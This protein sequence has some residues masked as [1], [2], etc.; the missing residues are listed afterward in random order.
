MSSKFA[1]PARTQ[2]TPAVCRKPPIPGPFDPAWPPKAATGLCHWKGPNPFGPDY[3]VQGLA[4]LHWFPGPQEYR[5]Q[6]VTQHDLVTIRA[7]LNY[8]PPYFNVYYEYWQAGDY[9]RA[10]YS[11]HHAVQPNQPIHLAADFM[12]RP[13]YTQ[14]VVFRLSAFPFT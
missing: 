13:D 14:H 1:R 10:A 9:K 3:F 7:T 12:V 11:Y 4:E 2:R 5:G 6:V 8:A